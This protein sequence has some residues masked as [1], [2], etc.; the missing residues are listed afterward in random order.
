MT[1][2][3]QVQGRGSVVVEVGGVYGWDGRGVKGEDD[4]RWSWEESWNVH[5]TFQEEKKHQWW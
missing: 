5:Q 1:C 2:L 3:T 4:G